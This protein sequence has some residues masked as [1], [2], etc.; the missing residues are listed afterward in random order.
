MKKSLALVAAVLLI[1]STLALGIEPIAVENG[2][3]ELPGLGKFK[4]WDGE[5]EGTVDVNGWTSD[6]NP[7]DSGVEQGWG[8]TDGSWSAFLMSNDASVWQVTDHVIAADEL[9]RLQ[10]DAKDNWQ[11]TTLELTLFA[12]DEIVDVNDPNIVIGIRTP[13]AIMDGEVTDAMQT[14]T[15]EC[16]TKDAPEAVGYKLGIELNNVSAPGGWIGMDNVRLFTIVPTGVNITWVTENID[17]DG[18]GVQDDLQWTD[19]LNDEG[20]TVDVRPDYWTSFDPIDPNDANEVPKID[21][22]NAADLVIISRTANSGNYDDGDEEAVWNSVAVPMLSLTSYLPRSSRWKWMPGGEVRDGGSPLIEVVDLDHPIFDGVTIEQL[23]I[24]DPNDLIDPNDPN[25]PIVLPD[26]IY[27]VDML[28]PS[29]GSGQTAFFNSIDMG[30]GTLIAKVYEA[31]QGSIAEWESGLEYYDG[32]GYIAG[33]HRMALMAGT[34]ETAAPQGAWNLT[35]EGEKILRNAIAYL[36]AQP[37][38]AREFQPASGTTGVALDGTLSWRA[39]KLATA[40]AV[41]L[42]TD[43]HAVANATALVDVVDGTSLDLAPLDLDLGRKYYWRVDATD[44]FDTWAGPVQSFTIIDY[45]VVDDFEAYASD[46]ITK[47]WRDYWTH[48]GVDRGAAIVADVNDGIVL[49]GSQSMAL[50]FDNSTNPFYFDLYRTWSGADWTEAGARY[51]VINFYGDANNHPKENL[52]VKINGQRV[53]YN[54]GGL[55]KG[56]WT[57]WTINLSSLPTP[58]WKIQK[59][60]ICVGTPEAGPGRKGIMYLDDLRLYRVAP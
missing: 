60:D 59:L 20:H 8:A 9:L 28:D 32:S 50:P 33:D 40:Y 6:E 44:G 43:E 57:Q 47:T 42:S 10:V 5:D 58:Q 23:N 36:L 4:C 34:T 37:L 27:G 18:D 35:A 16:D 25:A 31:D 22:L 56:E 11:A 15:L 52:W 7:Y 29:A 49:S 2:S 24:V 3:F 13:I 19:W 14:F 41:Y 51:L 46:T 48:D 17:R 55:Q 1:G 53:N 39:G 38:P 54:G 21:E 30:N 26:P 45:I 12:Y